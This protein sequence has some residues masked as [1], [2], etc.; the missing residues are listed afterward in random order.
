[1]VT[2]LLDLSELQGTYRGKL[3]CIQN[4]NR[5]LKE[6]ARKLSINLFKQHS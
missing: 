4:A 1:M 5:L 6:N 3:E 2:E